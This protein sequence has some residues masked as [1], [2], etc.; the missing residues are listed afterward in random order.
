VEAPQANVTLETGT[1]GNFVV[2]K[3]ATGARLTVKDGSAIE[4]L[5]LYAD[6][7]VTG[8]NKIKHAVIASSGV[9]MDKKPQQITLAEG[10]QAIAYH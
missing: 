5:T 8:G 6:A 4:N 3:V 2:D 10:G 9:S 7:E 1:V